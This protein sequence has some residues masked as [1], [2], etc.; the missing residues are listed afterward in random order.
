[1]IRGSKRQL[2]INPEITKINVPIKTSIHNRFDIEVVDAITGKI[3]NRAQAENII[4]NQLWTRLFTPAVYWN[5]VHYGTGTGTPDVTD[6]SLFNFYASLAHIEGETIFDSSRM[7]DEGILSYKR[8]YQINENAA[9]GQTITEVGIAYGTASNNLCTHAMLKDMNGNQISIAKTDTDLINI[10]ATIFVRF[11]IAGYDTGHI[12][13]VV[14]SYNAGILSTN[15][16]FR[17]LLR[18]DPLVKG[19]S[20]NEYRYALR[21]IGHTNARLNNE[22]DTVSKTMQSIYNASQKT[23]TLVGIRIHINDQNYEGGAQCVRIAEEFRSSYAYNDNGMGQI[24][25]L[26][27]GGE[28]Y[29]GTTIQQEAIGTGDGVTKDFATSFN[30]ASEAILYL[31]GQISTGVSVDNIPHRITNALMGFNVLMCGA[32]AASYGQTNVS[33]YMNSFYADNATVYS[34]AAIPQTILENRLFTYGINSLTKNTSRVISIE[35]SDDMITWDMVD[36]GVVYS[37]NTITV[38]VDYRFRRYWRLTNVNT[39]S[40]SACRITAATFANPPP[41]TNIHFDVAPPVGAVITADY[42]TKTIAKDVNHVFDLTVTIQL[43]EYTET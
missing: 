35:C 3:K 20:N 32:I 19:S 4:C 43:G 13:F 42:F 2:L 5:N 18:G 33:P 40:A 26:F 29:S 15:G 8:K 24:I 9:V 27:V 17:W 11:Q 14:N 34:S 39:S 10:Y 28:W 30:Y 36:D 16:F 41:T 38:P 31:D 37:G 7:M 25:T 6:T 1:M 22:A 23:L 21:P 12:K